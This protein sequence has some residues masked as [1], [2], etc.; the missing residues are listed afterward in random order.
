MVANLP[1]VIPA[2]EAEGKLKKLRSLSDAIRK[3]R[4]SLQAEGSWY[5]A[6]NLQHLK[7]QRDALL[8]L[9]RPRLVVVN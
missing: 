9:T 3:A 1:A 6:A 7:N 4:S 8:A 5:C 2:E